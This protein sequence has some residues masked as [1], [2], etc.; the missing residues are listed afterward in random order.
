MV[1]AG[2]KNRG[3]V[4]TMSEEVVPVDWSLAE[5]ADALADGL[6]RHAAE[7]RQ[8]QA[9]RGLDSLNEIQ[10]HAVMESILCAAGFGVYRE[11]RY[12]V[13]RERRRR[14]EGERCDFILTP[15]ERPLAEEAA[16]ATLFEPPA[17]TDP[18]QALWLEVKVV[19]QF[20]EAGAN[21]SYA[22]A[23]LHPL[24]RDVAKLAREEQ[25]RHAAVVLALFTRDTQT[26][27]HDLDLWQRRCEENGLA[28]H[29]SYRRRVSILDRLGNGC[30][31]LAI[32]RVKGW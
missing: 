13:A 2:N 4:V 17:T 30:C 1:R 12:P 6:S 10:L 5:I 22:S 21:R 25:I 29:A 23:L 8:A 26:A 7:D 11:Q 27:E 15:L 3:I 18:S 20:T 14:S 32:F 9:V 16:V 24:R 19:S 28:V 31:T